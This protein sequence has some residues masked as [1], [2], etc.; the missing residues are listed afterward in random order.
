MPR[1]VGADSRTPARPWRGGLGENPRVAAFSTGTITEI[2]INDVRVD[3]L[4]VDG[5][6]PPALLEGRAP[7]ADDE[8]VLG[9]A[10]LRDAGASVGDLVRVR[11]GDETRRFHVVGRAVFPDIGDI[12]QLGRGA[13]VTFGAVDGL[14]GTVP[15]NVALVRFRGAADRDAAV[16]ALT[17]G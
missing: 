14:G 8:I 17:R 13:F 1:S 11:V 4:A 6:T 7:R 16:G 5:D 9:G 15:H 3:A 12:G 2:A 10:T